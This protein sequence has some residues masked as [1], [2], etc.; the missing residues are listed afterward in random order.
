MT[1]IGVTGQ[2]CS[3]K[4]T[5]CEIFK[6]NGAQ[7]INADN[8]SQ[9]L[10]SVGRIKQKII[11]LFGKNIVSN[12]KIDRA[13]L[14]DIVFNDKKKLDLLCRLLHPLIKKEI[15]SKIKRGRRKVIIIDAPLLIEM[16]LDKYTDKVLVITVNSHVQVARAKKRGLKKED[17]KKRIRFQMPKN[18][19]LK[20]ADV[21]VKN[22]KD[23]KT[24]TKHILDIF[25]NLG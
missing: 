4:T 9:K 18:K 7:I 8:I 11:K 10:L 15:I 20:Y 6:N 19:F 21:I 16:G 1:V 3:G 17:L 25:K 5:A 14:A 2:I 24:F 22:N 23:K 13:K 12:S